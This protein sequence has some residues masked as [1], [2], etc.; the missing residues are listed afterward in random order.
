MAINLPVGDMG[1]ETKITMTS[2]AMDAEAVV[3]AQTYP[4]NHLWQ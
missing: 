1:R 4:V 2:Q 3:S